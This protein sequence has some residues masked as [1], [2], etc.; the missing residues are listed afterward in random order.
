MRSRENYA[1]RLFPVFAEHWSVNLRVYNMIVLI[2]QHE[3]H[4]LTV[5]NLQSENP[6]ETYVSS[7]HSSIIDYATN[8]K[9]IMYIH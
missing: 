6:I 8:I 4:G 2:N 9:T 5:K 7:I 3:T 1:A